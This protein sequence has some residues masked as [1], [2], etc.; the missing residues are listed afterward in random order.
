MIRVRRSSDVDGEEELDITS[1][2]D[3]TFLLL[4]FFMVTSVI[5][6]KSNPEL[7]SAVAGDTEEVAE[8]VILVLDFPEG[9]DEGKSSKLTGAQSI[10]LQ[11][12][13]IYFQDAGDDLISSDQLVE[14]LT[15]RLQEPGRTSKNVILQASRKMPAGVIREVLKRAMQ[16][17][18]DSVSVA[19]S[20]PN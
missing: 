16:A 6:Q 1:M 17:K 8:Q 11:Q 9:I 2:I 3:M 7:P 20:I 18:A 14:K 10:T 5:S 15:A 19:V 13:K 4:I 12:A